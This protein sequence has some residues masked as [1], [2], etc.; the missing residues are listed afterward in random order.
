MDL[1]RNNLVG[2]MEATSWASRS[3]IPAPS[4]LAS[5]SCSAVPRV[6]RSSGGSG[7]GAARTVCSARNGS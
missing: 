3:R 1:E 4:M 2:V 6:I 7:R 5:E